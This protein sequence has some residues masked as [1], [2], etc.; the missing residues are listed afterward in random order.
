M[1]GEGCRCGGER[2]G[3]DVREGDREGRDVGLRESE[4]N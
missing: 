4:D 3:R 1:R 2:E